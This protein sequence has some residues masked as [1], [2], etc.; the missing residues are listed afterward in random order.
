MNFGGHAKIAEFAF[1]EEHIIHRIGKA[2]KNAPITRRM[3][4]MIFVD[5]LFL[6]TML[7]P[8]FLLLAYIEYRYDYAHNQE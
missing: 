5:N 3:E 7:C 1:S 4:T 8:H 2:A 6:P